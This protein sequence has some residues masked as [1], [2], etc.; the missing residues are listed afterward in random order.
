[1]A[2]NNHAYANSH[3]TVRNLIPPPHQVEDRHNGVHGRG[4]RADETVRLKARHLPLVL[5]P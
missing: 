4:T 1:M 2:E 5:D 3:P